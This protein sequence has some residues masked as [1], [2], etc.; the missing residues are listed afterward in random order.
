MGT[1][2]EISLPATGYRLPAE[3]QVSL[4]PTGN[5]RPAVSGNSRLAIG[6]SGAGP[7]R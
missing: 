3:M 6:W 7:G 2:L 1:S 5:R 4:P